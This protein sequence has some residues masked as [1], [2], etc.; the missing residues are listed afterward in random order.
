MWLLL[1]SPF[2]TA[3]FSFL[4]IKGVIPDDSGDDN[5]W[6][7]ISGFVFSLWML[8]GFCTCSGIFVL[9]TASDREFKLRYLMNFVGIKSLAYYIGNFITDFILFLIPTLAFIILLFPMK[10]E[11]FSQNW[12]VILAIMTCF[13]ASLISLTYAVG[14]MFSSSNTAFRQIGVLYLVIG[15]FVPNTIGSV[16][17]LMSG[18]T[19]SK[20]IRS[21][22]VIDPFTPFYESLIYTVFRSLMKN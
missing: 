11:S 18:F 16:L 15:Y 9:P 10:V 3:I 12:G 4:I 20:I 1:A 8:I 5:F 17:G 14:F 7:I 2:I 13:G 6:L 21:I 19:G 22:L